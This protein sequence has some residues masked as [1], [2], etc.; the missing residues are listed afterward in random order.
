MLEQFPLQGI[1]IGHFFAALGQSVEEM[2]LYI[3]LKQISSQ[4]TLI[5]IPINEDLITKRDEEVIGL[6]RAESS[7]IHSLVYSV[8]HFPPLSAS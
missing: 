8:P 3:L 4:F 5:P 1:K 6:T 2:N 7:A